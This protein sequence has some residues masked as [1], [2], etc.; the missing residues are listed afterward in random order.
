MGLKHIEPGQNPPDDINVYIE[1]PRGS[2]IK[3]ESDE[4]GTLIVDRI[5]HTPM[6]YPLDYGYI[7]NTLS[8]DGDPVDVMILMPDRIP[9]GCVVRC[10]PIGAID[11]EDESG[12]DEKIIAVPVTGISPI[13]KDIQE[14][15]DIPE[16]TLERVRYFFE[17]YKDLEKGKFVKLAGTKNASE[18]KQL[19]QEGIERANN[20]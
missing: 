15:E 11:M 6:A 10:R 5:V 2:N 1:I 19:I 16:H 18:A 8:E 14:L 9:A 20:A 12:H 17:H 3:F 4:H 7:P 13:Y